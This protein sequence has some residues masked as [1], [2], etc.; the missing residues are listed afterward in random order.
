M[1]RVARKL[2][3][4]NVMVT[5]LAFVVL[6]GG[7]AFAAGQLGKNTVGSKQLRK[8]AVTAAKIKNGAITGA[9]IKNGAITGAKINLG[10]LGT[11]PSASNATTAGNANTVNGRTITKV[12]AKI[13]KGSTAT[14]ATIGPLTL[15]AECAAV[16]GRVESF[17]VLVA[18]LADMVGGSIGNEGQSFDQEGGTENSLELD[19]GTGENN[20]RGVASFTAALADGTTF[21]GV[22]GFDDT[23]TFQTEESCA[24][25]GHVTS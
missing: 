1:K 20:S 19:D 13:P 8:N 22:I 4:A 6:A 23:K 9:K 2:T 17:E 3:Y 14:I 21:S 25:F 11:V 10:S 16:S 7:T 15:T 12:F 24:F 18:P 5:I